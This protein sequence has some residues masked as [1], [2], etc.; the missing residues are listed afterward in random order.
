MI[1]ITIRMMI[2]EFYSKPADLL[3]AIGP[4]IRWCCY[5]V[6][7]DVLDMVIASTG[8]GYYH[9]RRGDKI[10]LDLPSANRLQAVDMGISEKNIWQ[11]EE[12]TFCYPER[13]YSFRF[14]KGATGRQG[15]FIGIFL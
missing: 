6:G 9:E 4:A 8:D 12:C 14:S 1:A 5:N 7:S 13:F 3:V 2:D 11:S 10:C 15:G